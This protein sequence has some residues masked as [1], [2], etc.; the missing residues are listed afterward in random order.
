MKKIIPLTLLTILLCSSCSTN[1]N[2][3]KYSDVFKEAKGNVDF[4]TQLHIFP[5]NT[6]SGTPKDFIYKTRDDLFTGSYVF[7]LVMQY[8]EETFNNELVRLNDVKANFY[9]EFPAKHIIHYEEDNLYLSV[10]RDSRYEYVKYY[11]DTKVIAYV[12]NQLY[13]W[14][15]SGVNSLHILGNVTIPEDLDD[16]ENSYNMY[17]YYTYDPSLGGHVGMYTSDE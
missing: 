14:P 16:G 1:K 6:D 2:I 9:D 7:Y 3:K 5:E 4:H 15:L 10:Y 13:E 17:Y 11:P 12:S 8:E